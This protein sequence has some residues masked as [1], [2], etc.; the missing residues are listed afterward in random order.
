MFSV[1]VL[2]FL[3]GI[4]CWLLSSI[5]AGGGAL[6]FL[7]VARLV[8]EPHDVPAVIAVASV[9]SSLHRTF[10]YRHSVVKRVWSANVS[11]LL[12][13][14]F[15]GGF[16]LKHVEADWL[17]LLVGVFLV[18]LSIQHFHGFKVSAFKPKTI[19]FSGLSLC[20]ASISTVVGVAGPLMNPLYLRAGILKESMIGTKAASTLF[21]QVGKL[22]VFLTLGMLTDS[23]LLLGVVVGVGALA[24]NWLG[25]YALKILSSGQFTNY[26]YIALLVSGL[27]TILESISD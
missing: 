17:G 16:F 2:L 22:T 26:V 3:F 1:A 13:G 11:G 27:S 14:T 25:R 15:L 20:T 19:H 10:L 18:V 4:F 5:A 24:G 23:S 6:L 7:P 8:L 12:I 21:M 9:I